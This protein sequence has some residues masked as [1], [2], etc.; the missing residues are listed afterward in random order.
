MPVRLNE[1]ALTG[2]WLYVVMVARASWPMDED[3][4]GCCEYD[5][6][7]FVI[8]SCLNQRSCSISDDEDP[9]SGQI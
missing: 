2:G 1:L 8:D 4:I 7:S 3:M 5:D 6:L 9:G